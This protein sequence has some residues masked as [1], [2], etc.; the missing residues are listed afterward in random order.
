MN[1]CCSTRSKTSAAMLCCVWVARK[2][3]MRKEDLNALLEFFLDSV[4][5]YY[6]VH[7]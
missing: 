1:R 5:Q 7:S 6:T 3:H 2:L 4:C